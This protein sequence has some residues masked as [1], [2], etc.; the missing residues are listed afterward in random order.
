MATEEKR[1]VAPDVKSEDPEVGERRTGVHDAA[2]ERL[3]RRD[4]A[5]R[6]VQRHRKIPAFPAARVARS[7]H[8]ACLPAALLRAFSSPTDSPTRQD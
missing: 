4:D 5:R 2:D 1:D 6:V 3:Q 8:W 7:S